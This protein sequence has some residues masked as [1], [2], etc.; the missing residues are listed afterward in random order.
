MRPTAILVVALLAGCRLAAAQQAPNP[1]AAR[2][3]ANDSSSGNQFT[4]LDVVTPVSVAE[5]IE[6]IRAAF[7]LERITLTRADSGAI[8]G[9]RKLR[10]FYVPVSFLATLTSEGNARTRV[11]LSATQPAYTEQRYGAPDISHP[12]TAVTATKTVNLD[13]IEGWDALVRLALLIA[14]VTPR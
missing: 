7:R 9:Q 6:R 5:T 12:A 14:N 2:S 1:A 11:R 13:G 8:E 3:A 4:T 10:G